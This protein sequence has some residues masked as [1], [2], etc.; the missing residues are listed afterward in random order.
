MYHEAVQWPPVAGLHGR[1]VDGLDEPVTVPY[2]DDAVS[3]RW[4]GD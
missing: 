3:S 1:G 4:A 2:A